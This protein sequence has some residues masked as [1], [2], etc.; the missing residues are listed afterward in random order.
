MNCVHFD[1][2]NDYVIF[3]QYGKVACH[4]A[5]QHGHLQVLKYLYDYVVIKVTPP[6]ISD[7][8]YIYNLIYHA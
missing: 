1:L 4:Y 5:A 6:V 7:V 2:N 8:S 3:F